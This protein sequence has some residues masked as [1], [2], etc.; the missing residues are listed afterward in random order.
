MN[1]AVS[2]SFRRKGGQMRMVSP[3]VS[4][5]A[6]NRSSVRARTDVVAR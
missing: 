3:L 4:A 1:A 6:Y 2:L 5:T